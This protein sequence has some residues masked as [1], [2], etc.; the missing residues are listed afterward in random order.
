[1]YVWYYCYCLF[2]P[3]SFPLQNQSHLI[4]LRC[5]LYTLIYFL[6]Y[7]FFCVAF[8]L[9][10]CCVISRGRC[11]LFAL[12]RHRAYQMAKMLHFV[13]NRGKTGFTT[14]VTYHGDICPG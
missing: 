6:F 5:L 8:C 14:L 11:S 3:P 2:T 12:V 10:A 4:S 9:S 1:M 13:R 7:F